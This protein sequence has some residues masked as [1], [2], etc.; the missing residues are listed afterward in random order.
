MVPP[1]KIIGHYRL[2]SKLGEGGM[3]EVWQA[4]DTKLNREVAIKILPEA[5]ASD[6]TR[7][8]RFAREAQVLASLNHPGIAAIYGVEER[9]LVME[10]VE[11]ETLEEKIRTGPMIAHDA[12][13]IARQLAEALS[14]AHDKGVIHRDLKPANIK[15]TPEGT[16]KILDF[17]LAKAMSTESSASNPSA[18]EAAT[19]TSPAATLAGT[20]LGTAAYMAPEQ[21][22]GQ[23]VDR[24]ADIWAFGVVLYEML[25]GERPFGGPTVSDTLAAVLKEAPDVTKVPA[26]ARRLIGLCLEKDPRKRLRDIGDAMLLLE[27]GEAS[28]SAPGPRRRV[29]PWASA[30][31][32]AGA[33][34]VALAFWLA[35]PKP[36][37]Q[38]HFSA[39]TNFAGVQANP[40]ISPD[41]RS[42]AF[43]S[44]R[45]GN[46]EL[47]VGLIGG[48]SLVEITHDANLKSRP[49][50][51]P[52][53]STLVYGELNASGLW[54]VWQVPALGGTP[55]RLIL[56]ADDPAWSPDGRSLAYVKPS[57][58][59]LWIASATGEN[60]R[61]L[62]T[63]PGDLFIAD[64]RF[65]PDGRSLAYIVHTGGPY[66]SLY[67]LD[68]SSGRSRKLTHGKS[69]AMSPAWSPDGQSI[70]F[71]SSRGGTMNIWKT[72]AGGGH[73]RQIT[74]GQ[75]DDAE[76]DV[77]ADGKS[78]VFSTFREN[79]NIGQMSLQPTAGE[80]AV[81]LL[82]T[83]PA[84]NQLAP[85]YSPDGKRLAYFT[86][87]KGAERES[88]WVSNADG[89][90]PIQL[91]RD[92]MI[93]IFPHWTPDNRHLIFISNLHSGP[94]GELRR[95]AIAGGAPQLLLK[96][97]G[98]EDYF[99]VGADG[100]VLFAPSPG[101]ADVFDPHTGQT[102]RLTTYAGA[103]WNPVL[104]SPDEK[105]IAYIRTAE[106][107]SDP[108]AGVWVKTPGG[109][110]RQI[111]Q[112]W[113]AWFAKG[114][115]DTIYILGG[116]PDLHGRLWKVAWNGSKPVLLTPRI[117]LIYSFWVHVGQN[118]QDYFDVSPDGRFLAF[119]EQSVLSAN[120]GRIENVR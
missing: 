36:A 82:T 44:N 51:S 56:D 94:L 102:Q 45:D 105:E 115:N 110:P 96:T 111:F 50:W 14:Y 97:K 67:V 57:D 49:A 89:S 28:P 100:R 11:G 116:S 61:L 92:S 87:L 58:A 80:P 31:L 32:F 73:L 81:R 55:H 117:P 106:S 62:V 60:P 104:W 98:L 7:L 13:P 120:I 118:S 74:A 109:S 112:G 68:L 43:V 63:A 35:R 59:T 25:S 23:N 8:A 64:P 88:I 16:V 79:T 54:D 113:V 93:D 17:G 39:V 41:G 15:I 75:G 95:V 108:Q 2:G 76:L 101:I 5:V 99:D 37:Q 85:Q 71:A 3:G 21:A 40:A 9:A 10:L 38:M 42:I 12:L 46:Y 103:G 22:R 84:R 90:D 30:G 24:R 27:S 20:V 65:S 6:P 34:L 33:G 66:G 70:Y 114:P 86:N 72:A 1:Q 53:G 119:A 29:L 91:V 107:D 83:D 52:D 78:I 4:T 26:F 19:L 69:L 77:S 47:Y 18:L 48:G